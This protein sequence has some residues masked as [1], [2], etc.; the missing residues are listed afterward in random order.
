[1]AE[2]TSYLKKLKFDPRLS[3]T[4]FAKYLRN[5]RLVVLLVF[6]VCMVG[7]TSFL[8]LPRVLNPEINIAIV[9]IATPLPGASPDD[10]ES[11]VTIP[12]EDSLSDLPDVK[13]ITSTSQ[14]SVSIVTL[15]FESGVSPDKA[16]ADVQSA[17]DSISDLPENA[18]NPRVQKLDFENQPVWTFALSSKSVDSLSLTRLSKTIRDRLEGLPSIERVE[19]AGIDDEEIQILI[20]PEKIALYGINPAVIAQTIKTA[21]GSFPAGTIATNGSSFGLSIDPTVTT[22]ND[23]RNIKIKTGMTTIMLSDVATIQQRIKPDSATS[24][25]ATGSQTQ[26]ETLR[27]DVYKTGSANITKPVEEAKKVTD[28][29]IKA[30]G[31]TYTVSTI[32]NTGEQIDEQFY[33]LIRDFLITVT[34]VFIALFLFLGIRQAVIASFAIPLTFLVTFLVMNVTGVPLSFIAFFSLLLSLGLLVD[35]TIVVISAVTAYYRTGKF[36]PFEAGMLVW[37]DFKTPILTTTLTTVWAFVP[38]L[39]STGII[40]EFI[41]AIPIVVSST[42]IASLGVALF[43]TLPLLLLLLK[44][45]IPY[46]VVVLFRLIGVAVVFA[47]FL[48]IMPQGPLFIPALLLFLLNLFVYFQV[49]YILFNR[50]R[51]N[52]QSRTTKKSSAN[53]SQYVNHG[54]INFSIVERKY[55]SLIDRILAKSINRRKT[56]LAVVIFSLFSYLLVPFGFV[57]NE[58]FPKSDSE[59]LYISVELPQGTNLQQTTKEMMVLLE[60]IRKTEHVKF[61]TATPRL[62]ID[63]A[64]GFSGASDNTALITVLLPPENERPISSIDMAE[65]FRAK[66]AGYSNGKISVIE[67]SGGPP[68]GSDLQI[69]LSGDDLAV[70][71]RY[72]DQLVQF[73]E[74]QSGVTNVSKSIKAGTS[75]IVFVPD[76][77]KMLAAG[78]TEDQLGLFMRTYASGFTM[79]EDAK[80]QAESSDSQNIVLRTATTQQTAQSAGT[81]VI[82]TQ[83]GPVPLSA[84]GSFELRPN[85]SLIT[86]EGGK[87]T[88]SVS[89][90]VT[91]GVLPTEENAKLEQFANT[92]TLPEGYEWQTGGINEENQ[93]SVNAILQAMLLS[94]FLIIVTM[95]LQ[96]SSFRKAFIVMLVIPLSISG[97]FIVFGLTHTPLSF[98]ALIGVLAL[99]GIVVKNSILIVDKINQNL[100]EKMEFRQAIAEAAE[101]RLEPITLTS[102]AAILG[103]IP[104]TLSDPFWRGL[105]G[106]IISGL[107]FSG[108]IMLIFIPVVYYLVF[109]KE[110]GKAE[111]SKS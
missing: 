2:L 27:F 25:I 60:D 41:R 35:D 59:Y 12:I 46:R 58:F 42:L 87:R 105:G 64:R 49:R 8:S 80:L 75:K 74:K 40:G 106:A 78:V 5:T 7:L 36:T 79:K 84:L 88:I 101:S 62:G 54:V 52:I 56:V 29:V 82:A 57:K 55:R 6:L 96:F 16:K 104:I 10:I 47:I 89:A 67:E 69:K 48:A 94:F 21:T 103:L 17:V 3:N 73:L 92:L 108:T 86:R 33:E 99:F 97:V 50:A 90:G 11:L 18:E 43:V 68:A 45:T 31:D 81:I 14:D 26:S 95:V 53:L 24:Y 107:L 76:T 72:A 102:I 37:R 71:D 28:E 38:L 85:P 109:Q 39:L 4:P 34:L 19:V 30:Y 110:E 51:K 20:E 111:K 100:K 23:L 32:L 83:N 1:M 65:N 13:T 66:Y 98:P 61:V 70:L 44:S 22:V 63:P 91:K 93:N 15:E 77:D 9:T